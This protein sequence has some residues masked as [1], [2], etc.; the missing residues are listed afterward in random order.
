MSISIQ[1]SPLG[2]DSINGLP[3]NKNPT[4]A[5]ELNIVNSLFNEPNKTTLQ[6]MMV[7]IKDTLLIAILFILFSLPQID[8]IIQRLVPPS[9]KS[10][11]ILLVIKS[12]LIASA[13]WVI[14]YF[15]LSRQ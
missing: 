4:N 6:C 7:D 11:Y 15:Y 10:I 14:R 2:G 13:W 9:S 12:L 3:M 5:K 8:G 1:Q